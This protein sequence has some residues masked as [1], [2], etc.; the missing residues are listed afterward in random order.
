MKHDHLFCPFS[1]FEFEPDFQIYDY[2]LQQKLEAN[3]DERSKFI[4]VPNMTVNYLSSNLKKKI[5]NTTKKCFNQFKNKINF[6]KS[7]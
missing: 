5:S 7:L 3:V 2:N 4:F 6:Q 1:E